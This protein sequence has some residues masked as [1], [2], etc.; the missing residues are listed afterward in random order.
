MGAAARVAE[1][2]QGGAFA[3]AAQR[4]DE[5]V[6]PGRAAVVAPGELDGGIR[7]LATGCA[8]AAQARL[9]IEEEGRD[10]DGDGEV[11]QGRT[12]QAGQQPLLVLVE[13]QRVDLAQAVEAFVLDQPATGE[14]LTVLAAP[15]TDRRRPATPAPAPRSANAATRAAAEA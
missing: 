3:L 2:D 1:L 9:E 10:P 13:D 11:L 8:L 6:G 12:L 5:R 14:L 7:A 15:D 4:P